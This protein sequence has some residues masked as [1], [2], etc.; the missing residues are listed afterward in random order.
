M[1]RRLLL[2]A[3]YWVVLSLCLSPGIAYLPPQEQE[4]ATIALAASRGGLYV[5]PA[6]AGLQLAPILT[7]SAAAETPSAPEADATNRPYAPLTVDTPEAEYVSLEMEG[8]VAFVLQ[9]T[10]EPG[11]SIELMINDA[12]QSRKE[13]VVDENG[14]WR[15]EIAKDSVRP[16]EVRCALRYVM[17]DN[18]SLTWRTQLASE[19]PE[20][21]A[22]AYIATGSSGFAGHTKGDVRVEAAAEGKPLLCLSNVDGSFSVAGIADLP[23][24]SEIL[25]GATDGWGNST[26]V[27]CTVVKADSASLQVEADAPQIHHYLSETEKDTSKPAQESAAIEPSALPAARFSLMAG[28]LTEGNSGVRDSRSGKPTQNT[29]P[30]FTPPPAADAAG[31]TPTPEGGAKADSFIPLQQWWKES[32]EAYAALESMALPKVDGEALEALFD[33]EVRK[34]L[35]DIVIQIE[36]MREDRQKRNQKEGEFG[37]AGI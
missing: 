28:Q 15:M 34:R 5:P 22:P 32:M 8:E 3:A 35:R 4:P 10:G 36:N 19:L 24:G 25:L 26:R 11:T 30:S 1:R 27:V 23:P 21:I 14:R 7:G 17:N 33:A 12:L 37:L 31:T 20:L 6:R 29:R 2:L 18:Y 13:A 16:G 9:G